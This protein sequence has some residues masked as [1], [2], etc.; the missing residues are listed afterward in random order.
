MVITMRAPLLILCSL[1]FV[2]AAWSAEPSLEKRAVAILERACAE[3]HSHASKKMKGG[4]ALDSRAALIEG[5]DTGPAI[6]PGEVEKSLLVTAIRYGDEDLEMPP[7]GKRLPAEDV[8]T[9]EAWIKAG[10]PWQ[11]KASNAEALT[12][13]PARKPGKITDEDRA[14]W[15]FQPL[16]KVEPPKAAPGDSGWAKNEV[17]AFIAAG[18]KEAGLTPAP[19]AERAT[20][21]RRVTYTLTGLPPKPEEVADFIADQSPDAYEKLV[22][23]LLAS[24]AYGEHW[25]RHW[26]DLV[27]YADSDGFRI[28]HYRPDA[29][30]YRDYVV[31]SF[32]ADKPY[33]RFVQEQIAGDELFPDQPEALVATGY[34]RHWSYE[35]N[36]RDV[37]TQRDNIVIDITDTTADVFMGLGLGCARC[38]DHKFDPLLQKDYFRLRAFFEPVLPRDDLTAATAAERAAHAKAMAAWEAKSAEV[39]G[40]IDALEAPYRVKAENKAVK[41]FPPETQAIWTKPASQRTPQEALYAELVQ[42]QVQYEYD[43]LMNYVKSDEKPKLIALQQELTAQEKNK[44]KALPVA[45]AATDVGPIA[46]PTV[47]P[48]KTALGVIEPGY[49]TILDAAPAKVP[50]P[51]ATSTNR[52]ATL[53]RWLTEETNP[54]TARVMVNRVWQYHFGAGLAI[55]SSDFGM[56]GEPPSHP[57]LLDWLTKRFITEGWSL[58]KLHRQ[59]L[60][61]ATWQQSATNPQAEAARLKDPENRLHWRSGTRRLAAEAIRDTVLSVTGEIDLTPGGPGVDGAKARRSLYVKVQ[62]NRRDALL[63][64]FDVAEGFASTANRN[65]TTTPR[66]SLLLFNGEWALARARAFAARLMKDVQGSGGET[67]AKRVTRAYQLAYGRAPSA[68]ELAA[69]S[70]F[71]GAQKAVGGGKQVQASLIADKLPFRDGRSAVLSPG[72]MQDRLMV[73]DRAALPVGDLTIEAFVLLRAPYENADVRTIA[74]RWNGDIKSPGWAFGVTGKRSR[75]KPMTLLLQLSSGADGA[76]E[77]EPLF[78]GLFLQPGRPYFVAVSV[79]LADG[80]EGKDGG[81]T[82]YIKDL[83]NDDE[84]MQVARV[85]HK[86]TILPEITAP[87]TIGGRWGAQKH[88]WDGLVDDVRLSDTALRGEQL[89]LTTEGLTDST[90]GYWRFETRTGAFNDS[91]PHGRHL[92]TLTTD[93]GARDTSLDAWVDFCH[94]IINSNELIYVD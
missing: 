92:M 64:V 53:A 20:L 75:Y 2:P 79:H 40:K 15:S 38:H 52:R 89:L 66:Q 21:I 24:P 58:K 61:S 88:L 46:P 6:V 10:A 91:S 50:A 43:R 34:L 87:L 48:R 33:D 47:I 71:L 49:P 73:G 55:N 85:P 93:S 44:P 81:V 56:L 54:L 8:A 42:R 19:Q 78:S 12:G 94:V 68:D 36:N 65:I 72:T 41:M 59:L 37:V 13:R 9:L 84:P 39:R 30:R 5:G 76:K 90:V 51:S 28:D 60:L 80:G 16:A 45:F 57:A 32:N 70:E 1:T 14:W 69:A 11:A 23:R 86:T 27:R 22:D 67:V 74:A 82:F 29:Y 17:D 26:L 7:K 3:C 31:R 62:R 77:A 4:L 18:L 63:D 25:A 35:Y 83:S